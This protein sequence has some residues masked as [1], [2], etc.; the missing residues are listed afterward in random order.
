[1]KKILGLDLGV[2]SIGWA[3]IEVSEKEQT[4]ILGMGSRIIPY[5]DQEADEFS[6]G[7]GESANQKRTKFRSIRRGIDRYQQRRSKL[8]TILLAHQMQPNAHLQGLSAL[9]LFGLRAKAA[10]EKVSLSEL[11]R[12]LMHLNQKRGYKHGGESSEE[13]KERE[14][15][16]EINN[17]YATIKGQLTVGQYFSKELQE[18]HQAGHYY[19]IKEKIFPRIAYQEE[20]DR[21]WQTQQQFHPSI[22]TDK[23]KE[24]IA[25]ET[26]FYQRPLKS[27][28][29]LVS[30]CEFEGKWRKIERE[31]KTSE[32]FTGPKVAPRTCPL[33]QHVRIWENINSLTIK[34]ISA[35]KK[36]H[37]VIDFSNKKKMLFDA[38]QTKEKLSETEIFKI[39][40]LQKSD[41]YYVDNN[42]A[43][44]GLQGNATLTKIIK[45]I[46]E[47]K[48]RQALTQFE[49]D[50]EIGNH[51]NH[52]TGE[53]TPIRQ[54]ASSFIQ[55]PLYRL[56]HI[57]Y[58]IK[59]HE[60]KVKVLTDKWNLSNESAQ[61][62]AALDFT[63][64]GFSNKSTKAIRKILPAL[65]E[66]HVYSDAMAIVGFNHSFSETKQEK[67][68]KELQ[69]RL[70]LLP[71]NALRQPIVEK[72]LNQMINLVNAL[73]V[74]HGH[75]DEI[76]VELARELR[77]S[78]EERNEYYKNINQKDRQHKN[79]ADRLIEYGVTANRKNI[80]KWK[81][82]HEVDGKCLYCGQHIQVADFLRGIE[83]DVEH[84]IP[85]S[86]FFDDSFSNKTIAHTKCN[87]EKGDWT[88]FEYM[89]RKS[90]QELARFLVHIQELYKSERQDNK[91]ASESAHCTTARIMR[92][93]FQKLQWKKED[94][95][96]DFIERQLQETR[97]I[98]KKAK[99]ILSKVS[100]NVY[101]TNGKITETLRRLWGWDEIIM[102]LHLP[103]YRKLQLTETKKVFIQNKEVHREIIPQWSKRDDHR[104][105]AIDALVVACTKQ[106][107]IQKLNTLH[108][109]VTRDEMMA[110]VKD[111][112][113]SDRLNLMEKY[114]ITQKPL[115]TKAVQEKVAN[116]IVSFKAGK[117]VATLG[118]RK[119]KKNGKKIKVQS[120]IIVPRGPLSEQSVYGKIKTPD[121][122]FKKGEL[123]K[124]PVKYLFE[125]PDL[126]FKDR[127]RKMV[128]ER[129]ANHDGD[130]KK[131]IASLKK[132]PIYLDE[133]QKT[134]LSFAT[135]YATVPVLKYLISS[136]KEKDLPYVVDGKIREL[137]RER[138]A[139]HNNNEKEA[140]KEPLY[141]DEKTKT[142]ILSVRCFSPS[143]SMVSQSQEN[144]NGYVLPK[145][146]HHIAI[147]QK[148]DGSLVELPATLWHAVERKAFIISY[149]EK[150]LRNQFQE[151]TVIKNPKMLWEKILSLPD[152]A[153][154]QSF[155]E[156]L[157]LEDWEFVMSMQKNEMFVIGK[158]RDEV[159]EMIEAGNYADLSPYIYRVQKL[160]ESDYYFRHHLE[161][162]VDDKFGDKK[163]EKLSSQLQKFIR[164]TSL[165]NLTR[166]D[167][168]KVTILNTGKLKM[169]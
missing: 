109:S 38:L 2:G 111:S 159:N 5:A 35:D 16:A 138:L 92:G 143:E 96:K 40:G 168:H 9:A 104:H 6:K 89:S 115:D 49:L 98:A 99:E 124:H 20:F 58:S 87:K 79:I 45:S 51:Y 155:L 91:T 67:L 61:K 43:A 153:V 4:S 130:S 97:Y 10:S 1:M 116:I 28:K 150:E 70:S 48:N 110:A 133:E 80:E 55:Q 154:N 75:F 60:E 13:K 145:N 81:L 15:V 46:Q 131:A 85:K 117:K 34:K 59:D 71:K 167:I 102:H 26:I 37:E 29:G 74:E 112:Q 23:L 106:G 82:W 164:I 62:L 169:G 120:G 132:E 56:W 142:P 140:F 17:R 39:L 93:K 166:P 126:I 8:Q 42:I 52:E 151:N 107:F 147:Y 149:F 152:D 137:I 77:Q 146:N 7:T 101:S 25:K 144:T 83:A 3:V 160:S 165:K 19:R 69:S 139:K 134:V 162:K 121:K 125:N 33:F 84:I 31:G 108:A 78:K 95:P 123:I 163:D 119:V 66:V 41:G 114:L 136:I 21:I 65:M 148:P 72:I 76:R 50:I 135:C 54:I 90:D 158:T 141:Y 14:W 18:A 47:D 30:I 36:K 103:K 128:K 11:G 22:L 100:R 63:T 156:K 105:H 118:I 24:D 127:I 12:V 88:A 53:I 86:F 94:I 73:M 32:I 129:L 27:Q 161:T 122:D 68:N 157:P 113:F 57:C 44:K 64:P